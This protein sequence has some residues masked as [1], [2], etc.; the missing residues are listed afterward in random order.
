MTSLPGSGSEAAGGAAAVAAYPLAVLPGQS[1]V[2]T[3]DGAGR[4]R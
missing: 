2:F 4:R 3:S 1:A